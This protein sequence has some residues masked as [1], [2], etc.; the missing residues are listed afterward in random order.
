MFDHH[1]AKYDA[2]ALEYTK[3]YAEKAEAMREEEVM[4]C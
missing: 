2:I 3:R 1:R 4:Y